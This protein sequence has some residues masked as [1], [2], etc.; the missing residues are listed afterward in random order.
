MTDDD[1]TWQVR[2]VVDGTCRQ[3]KPKLGLCVRPTF[4]KSH[5]KSRSGIKSVVSALA[6]LRVRRGQECYRAVHGTNEISSC[7]LRGSSERGPNTPFFSFSFQA[8][9]TN[10]EAKVG[11]AHEKTPVTS[12]SRSSF[13]GIYSWRNIARRRTVSDCLRSEIHRRKNKGEGKCGR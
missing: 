2:V 9:A 7:I 3:I 10:R 8:N 4:E 1:E 6:A 12:T 13:R 11:T 5:S